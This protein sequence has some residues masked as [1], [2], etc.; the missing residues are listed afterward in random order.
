MD[1][2][3]TLEPVRLYP[4]NSKSGFKAHT[5]AQQS[6]SA[7][8][9]GPAPF[10]LIGRLPV[11]LHI[12]ILTNLAIPDLL[13]YSRCS[14]ALGNLAK[15][16]RVWE[17]RWNA[18]GIDKHNLGDVLV[19]LEERA[20]A[21][22]GLVKG[23]APPTLSVDAAEDEFG[24]FAAVDA[25]EMG[26]FVGSN[27]G[28]MSSFSPHLSAFVPP[29]ISKPSF[30]SSYIRAHSL[31]KPLTS[32]LNSPPHAVLSVLFPSPSPT[33]R[34][35]AHTLRLLSLFLSPRAKPL[36]EWQTLSSALRA[37]TDRFEDALLTA[38][39]MADGKD[40]EAG[41]K[42]AA[43]ASWEV[44]DGSAEDW[45]L[46]RMWA[47]KREIFYQHKWKPLDNFTY[48]FALISCFIHVYLNIC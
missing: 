19:D 40:D 47:E 1:K 22:N 15:D 8:S 23:Q 6:L 38:F 26:D 28:T 31:L 33:V 39:D 25:N 18:F 14:R 35:Q 24:D 27:S 46:G 7:R 29:A 48:V 30:R 20:K 12:L 4:T 11:D 41:M 10:Q 5:K 34:Q 44:W 36:R 9:K 13:A 43:E 45:E 37:A 2:F 32:A 16:E 17:A 42:Q 3:A 21:Q